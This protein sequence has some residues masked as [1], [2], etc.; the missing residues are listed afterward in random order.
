VPTKRRLQPREQ[1]N[2]VIYGR[3]SR[4]FKTS[5]N[6]KQTRESGSREDQV[7]ACADEAERHGLQVLAEL[8]EPA[9][10][11]AYKNRGKDR[12]RWPELLDLVRDG[13]VEVVVAYK[14]DRLSR[15]GGPGWAPLI[16]AAE[17]AG[18][19]TDRF[20]LIAGSGYMTEFELGI[21]A[22][23]DREESRKTSDRL[24]VAHERLAVA[25]RFHGG[26]R[27]YG[28]QKDGV[29]IIEDEAA[30][31]RDAA[32]RV[33]A[34]ES[35]SAICHEWNAAGV[36]TSTGREWRTGTLRTSLGSPR[37]AALRQHGY[38]DDNWRAPTIAGQAVWEPVVD[39]AT[40][41][42]LR[43]K[44]F[45]PARPVR[46]RG[47]GNLLTGIVRCGRCGHPMYRATPPGSSA[48]Y[49]CLGGPG[50]NA[51]GRMAVVADPTETVV[52]DAVFRY[53]ESPAFAELL[54]RRR[55]QDSNDAALEAE[56]VAAEAHLLAL[57]AD[58][59]AGQLPRARW[60]TMSAAAQLRVEKARAAV[61]PARQAS[62]GV[63]ELEGLQSRW[64]TMT[65]D[66]RRAAIS[67]LVEA[68]HV[69]PFSGP[70]GRF[71]PDRLTISW[72]A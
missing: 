25:G 45:G 9:S 20:V 66:R 41:D 30:N 16:E 47:A 69:A 60:L 22:A 12:P 8:V 19:D 11:G 24:A 17:A 58:F 48:R 6:D 38:D 37:L 7:R 15:G 63:A 31:L 59:G 44:L 57:D 13:K 2:A 71:D 21:R 35:L 5:K 43:A 65:M 3:Q 34:G 52:T 67:A 10:T 42:R 33:L 26:R 72:W 55:N 28:Y 29:T 1:R 23:M 14:T 56:L 27:A 46:V 53:V 64:E 50:K 4:T 40:H 49:A 62:S 18:L 32:R 61:G 39:R 70:K 51:C 68:V 36:R 54:R